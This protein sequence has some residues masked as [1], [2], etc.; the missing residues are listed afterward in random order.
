[1]AGGDPQLEAAVQSLEAEAQ[2][3]IVSLADLRARLDAIK[4]ADVPLAGEAPREG[5]LGRAFGNVGQL[6]TVEEQD[7]ESQAAQAAVAQARD[8]LATG[9]VAGARDA[10]APLARAG[11]QE[12]A[13]WVEAAEARLRAHQ[14]IERARARLDAMLTAAG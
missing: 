4:P 6:V 13:A 10:L 12:V 3:G 5:W 8:R 14:E 7:P 1:V 9:D 11:N 2:Q